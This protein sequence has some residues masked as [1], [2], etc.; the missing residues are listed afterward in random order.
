MQA[1]HARDGE[2]QK[3]A[4]TLLHVQLTHSSEHIP[5]PKT[6]IWYSRLDNLSAVVSLAPMRSIH[7]GCRLMAASTPTTWP[8]V[9]RPL[10]ESL[11]ESSPHTA[12][13]GEFLL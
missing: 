7:L 13:L 2:D 6:T 1:A 9:C 10:S 3:E 4:L 12:L 5:A 11:T 8:W